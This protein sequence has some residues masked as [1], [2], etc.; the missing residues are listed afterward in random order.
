MRCS[1]VKRTYLGHYQELNSATSGAAERKCCHVT[2][3]VVILAMIA[4]FLGLRLYAVLGRRAEH[5]EETI[6]GRFDAN[7]DAAAP[8]APRAAAPRLPERIA[9]PAGAARYGAAD[10]GLSGEGE[11]AQTETVDA[12]AAEMEKL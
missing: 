2:V 12:M 9:P 8:L 7:G 11:A 10:A 5:E 4:A 6:Q 1:F 3:E